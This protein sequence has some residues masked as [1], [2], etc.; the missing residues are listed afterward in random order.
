MWDLIF[1]PACFAILQK[2]HEQNGLYH[3]VKGL[4]ASQ[5]SLTLHKTN[6]D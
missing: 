1:A 4:D 6:Q 3:L 5:Q 2:Y